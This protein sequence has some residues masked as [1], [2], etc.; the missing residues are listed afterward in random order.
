MKLTSL[1]TN[2]F[3]ILF[4]KIR[5]IKLTRL[6]FKLYVPNFFFKK[7]SNFKMFVYLE[8]NTNRQSLYNTVNK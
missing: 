4:K 5:L 7:K 6:I 8:A 3:R 2:I 1:S